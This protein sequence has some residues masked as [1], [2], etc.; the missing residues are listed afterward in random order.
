MALQIIPVLGVYIP[1]GSPQKR[2]GLPSVRQRW[3]MID[4]IVAATTILHFKETY[5]LVNQQKTIENGPVE[6][7]DLPK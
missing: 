7:V 4:G 1:F 6:I 3:D 2:D 5:P